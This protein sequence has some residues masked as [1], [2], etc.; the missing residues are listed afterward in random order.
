MLLVSRFEFVYYYVKTSLAITITSM[1]ICSS[2][3]VLCA[4]A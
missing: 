1:Q 4:D 2:S 3:C